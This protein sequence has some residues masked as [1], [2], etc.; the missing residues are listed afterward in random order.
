M[1]LHMASGGN[2]DWDIH[3]VSVGSTDH[4]HQIS[5]LLPHGPQTL[6]PPSAADHA[7]DIIIASGCSTGH[8]HP[9][10]PQC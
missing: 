2:A 6:S 8:Q 3:P 5:P 10:D 7:K 9:K 4:G 1:D